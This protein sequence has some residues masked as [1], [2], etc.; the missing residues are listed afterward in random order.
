[1]PVNKM[2]S[3]ERVISA[4]EE[5]AEKSISQVWMNYMVYH[6]FND[7]NEDIGNL[8]DMLTARA[9]IGLILTIPHHDLFGY[10]KQICQT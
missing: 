5:Y 9:K 3:I 2:F 4:A 8:V 7:T 6:G 10:K 1:M